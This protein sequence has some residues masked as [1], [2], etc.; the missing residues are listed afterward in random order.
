MTVATATP[1][2]EP[3]TILLMVGIL[4]VFFV[5]FFVFV[6]VVFEDGCLNYTV[7]GMK[8]ATVKTAS[9]IIFLM[10]GILSV[11]FIPYVECLFSLEVE[12]VVVVWVLVVLHLNL[13]RARVVVFC[14]QP[15][16][17]WMASRW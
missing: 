10:V 5:F 9:K 11:F 17:F 8:I 12:T 7:I 3:S 6:F 4:C 14:A 1:A 2:K 15:N 13:V 16:R